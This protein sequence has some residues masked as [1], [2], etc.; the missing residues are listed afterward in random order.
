M[1]PGVSGRLR[2]QFA[3]GLDSYSKCGTLGQFSPLALWPLNGTV[4]GCGCEH[5]AVGMS[6]THAAGIQALAA[7]SSKR[8]RGSLVLFVRP[9]SKAETGE[10]LLADTE[11]GFGQIS[12]GSRGREVEILASKTGR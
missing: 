4:P 7:T 12:D 3:D 2:R 10:R 8:F 9:V 11:S 1:N 5:H 6:R